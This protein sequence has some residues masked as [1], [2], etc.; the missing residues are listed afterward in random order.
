VRA[1]NKGVFIGDL[2]NRG[3][4]E[5]I[6]RIIESGDSFTLVVAPVAAVAVAA[7][8]EA[9]ASNS[10]CAETGTLVAP[11]LLSDDFDDASPMVQ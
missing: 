6:G 2:N 5:F 8:A 1:I 4:A 9:G 7:A 11:R 10:A 3:A